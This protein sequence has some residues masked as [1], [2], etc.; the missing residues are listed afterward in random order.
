MPSR[1]SLQIALNILVP[2]PSVCST[3]WMPSRDLRSTH[4]NAFLRSISGASDIVTRKAFSST[5]R[6]DAEIV[7]LSAD[8]VA[9]FDALRAHVAERLRHQPQD[10]Q[11]AGPQCAGG[12]SA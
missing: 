9:D 4:R 10:R 11:G 7:H 8:G 6:L 1:P 2:S 3:Y 12:S 5:V